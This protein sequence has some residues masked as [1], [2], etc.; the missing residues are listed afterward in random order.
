MPPSQRIVEDL[1]KTR[2]VTILGSAGIGKTSVAIQVGHQLCN[3]FDGH[4]IFIDLGAVGDASLVPST[5]LDGVGASALDGPIKESL[6]AFLQGSALLLILDNCEHVIEAAAALAEDLFENTGDIT[7]LTT[8]REALRVDGEQVYQLQPLSF[9]QLDPAVSAEDALTYPAVQLFVDRVSA[10]LSGLHLGKEEA[11]AAAR[12]CARL[13]G[14]PLAIEIAA[15]R[16]AALGILQTATL[17]E[18]RLD[19]VWP[20]R[21]TALP[22]QRTLSA[23]LDW[24]YGLLS[25]SEKR[26]LQGLS[27]FIGSF[28]LDA[29]QAIAADP[30]IEVANA[31]A[32]LVSK[33]L[34]SPPSADSDGRLHLLQIT[35]AYAQKQLKARGAFDTVSRRHAEY[36]CQLLERL[37]GEYTVAS[38]SDAAAIYGRHIGNVRS[39][40]EWSFSDA[41]EQDLAWSLSAQAAPLF[42]TLSLL[43]ECRSW[44]MRAC[45]DPMLAQSHDPRAMKSIRSARCI[46]NVYSGQ[47]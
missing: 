6:R 5:V 33:S 47:Q 19:L 30:A 11:R 9:P 39:A 12:I 26:V 24:S 32:S 42:I 7:I 27:V 25:D 45:A 13:D 8:S 17:L 14:I 3:A 23:A 38:A 34:I 29:A 2:F 40:L 21:R 41:G 43:G 37:N 46:I 28:G 10:S 4:V 22:R 44:M 36:F 15:S 1:V 35:K 16:A 18:D 31:V 20:G